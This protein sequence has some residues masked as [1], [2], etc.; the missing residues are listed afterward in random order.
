[1]PTHD[2]V[3]LREFASHSDDVLWLQEPVGTLVWLSPAFEAMFGVPAEELLRDPSSWQLLLHPDDRQLALGAVDQWQRGEVVEIDYRIIRRSDGAVRWI[4]N[5]GFPLHSDDGSIGCITGI[6]R[7]VTGE[8]ETRQALEESEARA[9]L[10][11]A[12]LQHRV[13]NTL[14]VVRAIA[15]RTGEGARDVQDY[16]TQLDGRLAAFARVQALMTRDPERGV[17]LREI[18]DEELLAHSAQIGRSV[19][20]EGPNLRLDQQVAERVSLAVHELAANAVMHGVLGRCDG[21]LDVRW[22]VDDGRDGRVLSFGWKETGLGRT[23]RKPRRTGFGTELLMQA[24]PF[25]LGAKSAMH[26]GKQGFSYTLFVPLP[27]ED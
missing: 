23:L 3:W 1:M 12:E 6:A 25:G 17:S 20:V 22:S 18:I 9:R 27:S 10:L 26:F 4:R 16:V 8:K 7:D 13:R 11:L 15:R 14:G 5:K 19:T 2:E 21:D 24:L